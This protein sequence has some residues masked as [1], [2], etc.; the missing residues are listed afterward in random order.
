MAKRTTKT[1]SSAIG[2]TIR[3]RKGKN[4]NALVLDIVDRG[5]RR[6]EHL[7][8]Y[9][10]GD[11]GKDREAMLLAEQIRAKRLRERSL[12]R[13]GIEEL[14]LRPEEDFMSFYEELTA[15]RGKPW[16]NV[17]AHLRQFVTGRP[18]FGDI[19]DKW[20]DN[21]RHFLVKKGLATNSVATYLDVVKTAFNIAVKR[22]I[23]AVS[24]FTYARPIKRVKT[25]RE[26][27]TETELRQL[28]NTPCRHD[29]VRRSFL[30][31]CLTG[32]RISDL[33]Q[34]QWRHVKGSE[35]RID[36]KKT[37][38]FVS[39]PL[40]V[41][42]L[43]LLPDRGAAGMNDRIFDFPSR[44]DVYN[45]RLQWW[46]AD[47]GIDKHVTSHIARHTFATLLI[48]NATDLYTVQHLLGHRDI[49]VTQVYAKLVDERKTTAINSLGL[50]LSDI[51]S[52]ATRTV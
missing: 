12:R 23:I 45:R 6:R 15:D 41:Q 49:K 33:R 20:I 25:Q 47:A 31:A 24:P 8:L 52:D 39:V 37:G 30:F 28:F 1:T 19:D 2:V 38:D 42:S 44:D 32:L 35:L 7:G 11:R 34:L 26:Y 43:S 27:L 5:T 22:R 17:L 9:L 4:A 46:V 48:T 16:R 10:T 40:N 13:A 36:Q 21:F 51:L 3:I 14:Q 18:R 29:M 50:L